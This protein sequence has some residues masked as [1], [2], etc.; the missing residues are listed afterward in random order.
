MR[1]LSGSTVSQGKAALHLLWSMNSDISL[2]KAMHPEFGSMI[3]QKSDALGKELTPDEIIE[4]FQ[5]KL[6]GGKSSV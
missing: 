3:K 2:P 5:G 1:L 4:D 6:S